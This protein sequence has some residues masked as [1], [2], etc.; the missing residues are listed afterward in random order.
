MCTERFA[1][2]RDAFEMRISTSESEAEDQSQEKT[3]GFIRPL[4][5]DEFNVFVSFSGVNCETD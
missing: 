3:D 1:V 4:R 5:V 2:E